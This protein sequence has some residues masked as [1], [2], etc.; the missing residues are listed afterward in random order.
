MIDRKHLLGAQGICHSSDCCNTA[1]EKSKAFEKVQRTRIGSPYVI[2]GME[3]LLEDTNTV[4]GYEAN[5]GFLLGSDIV[6]GSKLL[7]K[8]PTEGCFFAYNNGVGEKL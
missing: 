8:L 5:G 1:L 7:Q 2:A 3:K 6:E 4:V